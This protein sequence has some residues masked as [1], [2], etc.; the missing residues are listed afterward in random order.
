[1]V[2]KHFYLVKVI[3]LGELRCELVLHTSSCGAIVDA[4]A[5]FPQ[6]CSVG[7]RRLQA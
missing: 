1:M 4:M 3:C 6:A 2:D 7:A 5:R